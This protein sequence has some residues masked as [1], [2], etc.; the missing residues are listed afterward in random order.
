[1]DE[2]TKNVFFPESVVKMPEE[3]VREKLL[4]HRL[5][6]QPN[7][8]LAI[9][10]RLCQTFMEDFGADVRRLFAEC[11]YSVEQIREY[12]AQNKKRLPYLGGEKILNYWLYVME[13][14]AGIRFEDRE[15]ITIAPDTHVIQSSVQ[16]GLI[17]GDE[18]Q[19][20]DVRSFTAERWKEL[21]EGSGYTPID[22]HTPLWLWSRNGF[23]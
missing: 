7:R 5:A 20:S 8:H 19:R 12:F 23:K 22:F 21:L 16:L 13:Q 17:T 2:E 4:R 9:W 10:I 18:A 1:L 15:R 6:L 3:E 14:R 11:G